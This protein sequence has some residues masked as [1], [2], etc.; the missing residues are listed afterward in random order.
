MANAALKLTLILSLAFAACS[1]DDPD[2][3]GTAM[4][5]EA[6]RA[7][8]DD[9][10]GTALPGLWRTK[11]FAQAP[12]GTGA[13]VDLV[14]VVGDDTAWHVVSL[15]ADEALTIPL[16]RWDITREYAL[17]ATSSISARARELDWNDIESWLTLS[18]DDPQL[19]S[20]LLIDDCP[21]EIG[22]PHDTSASNCGAPLFP[23]RDC[24]MM[25]FAEIEGGEL[26][27]GDPLA[28]D[29]CVERVGRYEA[30]SFDRVVF[31]SEV[32]ELLEVG[33]ILP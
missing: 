3:Y 4:V 5:E 31:S 16:M 14:W 18:V 22:V 8:A 6:E 24:M 32:R 26:T 25:D 11:S 10:A 29:R 27:F 19:L 23:F 28:V 13:W 1:D 30:W 15:Y 2:D 7:N 17:G 33:P 12:D 9:P 20:S 21:M